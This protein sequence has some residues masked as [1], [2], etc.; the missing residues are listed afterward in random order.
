MVLRSSTIDALRRFLDEEVDLPS[1]EE[2]LTD[3]VYDDPLFIGEQ[4]ILEELRLL[5]IEYGEGLRPI[6][7]LYAAMAS[8]L[9][10][11]GDRV[12][13]DSNNSPAPIRIL[14]PV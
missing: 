7:D 14:A 5:L 4:Q 8:R 12:T 13:S 9:Q 6:D 3:A 1:F 11:E 2:W 10:A